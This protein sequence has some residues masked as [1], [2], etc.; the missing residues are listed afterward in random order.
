MRR[1]WSKRAA[2]VVAA[3][4]TLVGVGIGVGWAGMTA[5]VDTSSVRLR[6]VQN[7][8]PTGYDSGWHT[9]P[10]LVVVQVT[11]GKLKMYQANCKPVV[12]Q[13]GETFVEVPMQALRAVA[14]AAATWTTT[15]I[16]PVGVAPAT[17]VASPCG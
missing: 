8:F 15:L 7:D 3:A 6:V 14:D 11:E 13:A 2:V 9:H 12:V 17:P 4:T 16:V 10:G 1:T 5:V